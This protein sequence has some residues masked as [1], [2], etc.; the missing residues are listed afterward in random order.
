MSLVASNR[1]FQLHAPD[2]GVC[3]PPQVHRIRDNLSV[4]LGSSIFYLL[5]E[6]IGRF[7]CFAGL[8]CLGFNASS[9]RLSEGSRCLG[10]RRILQSA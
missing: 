7:A 1:A 10:P 6:V 3:S 2:F 5:R 9:W 8:Q 4:V